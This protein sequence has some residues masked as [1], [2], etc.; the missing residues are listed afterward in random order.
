MRRIA[1]AS[2]LCSCWATVAPAA[3]PTVGCPPSLTLTSD[4]SAVPAG[5]TLFRDGN[6]PQK[7]EPI[8]TARLAFFSMAFADGPP[9][10]MAW[11]A[12]D[13]T[14]AHRAIWRFEGVKDVWFACTYRPG[15]WLIARSLGTSVK[16][17]SIGFASSSKNSSPPR[18]DCR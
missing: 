8:K 10:E 1:I 18:V 4:A 2:V 7:A 12:P 17:C 16:A 14:K 6:P 13:E 3:S 15:G 9:Q 5:F 11:L